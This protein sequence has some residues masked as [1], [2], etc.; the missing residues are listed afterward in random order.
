MGFYKDLTHSLNSLVFWFWR[1]PFVNLVFIP[2]PETTVD[3]SNGILGI[4]ITMRMTVYKKIRNN[5]MITD[6]K[7]MD[8]K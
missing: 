1:N 6:S 2:I 5:E 3:K 8:N 4:G 7:V